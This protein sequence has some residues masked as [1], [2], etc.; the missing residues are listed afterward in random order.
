MKLLAS[1]EIGKRNV[2][3]TLFPV[4]IQVYEFKRFS[5]S[6]PQFIAAT[7]C[8]GIATHKEKFR[9]LKAAK[10]HYVIK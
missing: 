9:T 8:N 6:K 7:V 2:G 1:K 10:A 3:G 4:E 5:F